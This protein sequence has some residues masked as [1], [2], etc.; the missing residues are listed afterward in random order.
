M[1]HKK[2]VKRWNSVFKTEIRFSRMIENRIKMI[3]ELLK[4]DW[5]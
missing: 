3:K 1:F 4:R 2:R 5:F